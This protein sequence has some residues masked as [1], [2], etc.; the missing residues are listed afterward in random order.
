[1]PPPREP[2]L[3]GPAMPPVVGGGDELVAEL[4]PHHWGAAGR[5]S[6]TPASTHRA[7]MTNLCSMKGLRCRRAAMGLASGRRPAR[8]ARL[9]RV[10]SPATA[11]ARIP[12]SR[13]ARHGPHWGVIGGIDRSGWSR[14]PLLN[15]RPGS[16]AA[17][18]LRERP[19]GR[20]PASAGAARVTSLRLRHLEQPRAP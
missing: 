1:M 2:P 17:R 7:G 19:S 6:A 4:P 16:A 3:I 9:S 15:L 5:A 8:L 13:V 11:W 18:R 10:L 14:E 12:W 20:A